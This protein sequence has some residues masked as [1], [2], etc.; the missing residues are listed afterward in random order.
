MDVYTVVIPCTHQLTVHTVNLWFRHVL[1]IF[2]CF[3]YV[4]LTRRS[5]WRQG[6]GAVFTPRARSRPVRA[7]GARGWCGEL[8]GLVSSAEL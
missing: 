6:P 5:G 3:T 7:G 2:S 4:S 1:A 8:A